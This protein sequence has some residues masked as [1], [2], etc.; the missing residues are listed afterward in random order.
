M[1]LK[2]YYVIFMALGYFSFLQF[3]YNSEAMAGNPSLTETSLQ[4]YHISF[5]TKSWDKVRKSLGWFNKNGFDVAGV[6]RHKFVVELIVNKKEIEKLKKNGY[7]GRIVSI[8]KSGPGIKSLDPQ[9]LNPDKLEARLKELSLL[10]PEYTKLEVIG[11]SHEGRAIY[12]LLVSDSIDLTSDAYLA[13]PTVLFDGMHHAREIMTSE[14]VLDVAEHL[15]EKLKIADGES[16]RLVK[17]WNFWVVPML[18]VDGNNIVWKKNSMW[19]KNAYKKLGKV[20][21]VD[22]NRNYSYRWNDCGGSSGYEKSQTYRGPEAASEPEVQ[23]LIGLGDRVHPALSVSY[24]SYSELILYPYSCRGAY[25]GENIMMKKLASE[26][27]RQLPTDKG[28]GYNKPGTPWEILYSVDGDS[29][30]YIH[31]AYGALAFTLEVNNQFQPPYSLRNPT[32]KKHRLAWKWLMNRVA[33]NVLTVRVL[34]SE[35]IPVKSKVS[36]STIK[37][38]E[39]ELPFQTNKAGYFFRILDPGSYEV[40]IITENKKK[41]K[42]SVEMKGSRKLDLVVP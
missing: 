12:A 9:Y 39:G 20:V 5:K 41:L 38:V 14:I 13:K 23:A 28:R 1:S 26:M 24:H 32:V 7:E 37:H 34:N 11:R 31:A 21:G 22:P 35:G 27:S 36:I 29:M 33:K 4:S 16:L 17:K 30:S 19:R 25:S 10:A 3:G 6:N 40:T 8:S 18:N 15:V 2:K 42:V